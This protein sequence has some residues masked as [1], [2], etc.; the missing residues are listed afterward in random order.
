MLVL[1]QKLMTALNKLAH[2]DEDAFRAVHQS[3]TQ[4]VSVRL[5]RAKIQIEEEIGATAPHGLSFPL[6]DRIPWTSNG[7][8]LPER[9]SFTLDPLFHAG[10]YYVQE[11]S[12]MFVEHA[13]R[14]TV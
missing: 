5:N 4:V 2:F 10:V 12:G 7:F 11:A 14:N 3:D 6:A 9:P 8:Y 13:L 1:P